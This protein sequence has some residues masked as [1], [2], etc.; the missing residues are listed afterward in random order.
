MKCSHPDAINYVK[1]TKQCEVCG[2]LPEVEKGGCGNCIGR[3]NYA[4]PVA[5]EN[6]DCGGYERKL[7][8]NSRFNKVVEEVK[9]AEIITKG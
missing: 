5:Y 8:I 3:G 7:L 2:R 6:C 4:Y 9:R 1:L